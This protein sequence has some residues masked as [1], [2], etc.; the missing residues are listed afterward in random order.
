[1]TNAPEA[2]L[3][4]KAAAITTEMR[5]ISS[6]SAVCTCWSSKFSALAAALRGG[7]DRFSCT[8]HSFKQYSGNSVAAD[9][10]ATAASETA[11]AAVSEREQLTNNTARKTRLGNPL[12]AEEIQQ[13]KDIAPAAA[14]SVARA[15]ADA[16]VGVLPLVLLLVLLVV[17]LPRGVKMVVLLLMFPLPLVRSS[18]FKQIT[19]EVGCRQT[20]C[21]E[22]FCRANAA[23]AA[24]AAPAPAAA[25]RG[26]S[27]R[28]NRTVSWVV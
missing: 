11:A 16:R 6:K 13:Q 25:P 18:S 8:V 19:A 4:R 27:Y 9:N 1:M 2:A 20:T 12:R 21:G 23:G 28:G 3:A 26:H 14:A 10:D 5:D 22:G 24:K 15:K 7:S 17:L